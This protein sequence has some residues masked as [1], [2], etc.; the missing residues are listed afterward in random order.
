MVLQRPSSQA[1]PAPPYREIKFSEEKLPDAGG[2]VI[3]LAAY[4]D[5]DRAYLNHIVEKPFWKQLKAV[6]RN[7]VY[8][9]DA[10]TWRGGNLLAAHAIIDDLYKYLVNT[11]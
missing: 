9:V 8:V 2:D 4:Y 7:R 3:L 10:E 6:Q 5:S 1:T 11:P